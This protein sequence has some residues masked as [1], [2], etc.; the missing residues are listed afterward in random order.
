MTDNGKMVLTFA[1]L[2]IAGIALAELLN[3]YSVTSRLSAKIT[4]PEF[5]SAYLTKQKLAS[6]DN[7]EAK[8]WIEAAQRRLHA[9]QDKAALGNTEASYFLMEL[10][11]QNITPN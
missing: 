10:R 7:T 1:G 6:A 3:R 5:A 4:A 8:T 9:L 11:R 2:G